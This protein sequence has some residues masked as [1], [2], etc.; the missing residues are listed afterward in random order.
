MLPAPINVSHTI[1]VMDNTPPV[2]FELD[3][4]EECVL[5]IIE[6]AYDESTMDIMPERPDYFRFEEGSD[7]LDIDIPDFSDNCDLTF[8]APFNV[9][10][11]VVFADG[12]MR[13]FR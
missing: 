3:P 12:T 2:I 1:T 13:P 4:L 11:R 6:A 8:C 9:R 7:M 10:W 5:P